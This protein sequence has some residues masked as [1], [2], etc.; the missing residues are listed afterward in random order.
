M[1]FPLTTKIYFE[2]VSHLSLSFQISQV[3]LFVTNKDFSAWAKYGKSPV[4]LGRP[5]RETPPQ[6]AH[7]S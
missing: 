6:N 4:T 1:R 5:P 2:T 7:A 3:Y